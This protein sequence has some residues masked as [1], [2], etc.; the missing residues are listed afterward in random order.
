V[1]AGQRD[2]FELA[3]TYAEEKFYATGVVIDPDIPMHTPIF[4][5]VAAAFQP[6]LDATHWQ[7]P[8][9]VYRSNVT[10]KE[11]QN[12]SAKKIIGL[13][14][15]HVYEPVQWRTIIDS[16]IIK[17]Q[18]RVFIEVGPRT[19]VYDLLS[20]KWHVVNRQHSSPR[21]NDPLLHFKGLINEF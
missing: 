12:C 5:P 9:N 6:A 16:L 10:G 11:Y 4:K 17:Y 13:L 2:A 3:I 14:T 20:P 8:V 1:V 15:R 19:V 18:K 7:A 21:D